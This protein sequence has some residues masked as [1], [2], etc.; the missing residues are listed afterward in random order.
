MSSDGRH[1]VC[2]AIDGDTRSL[3]R[4]LSRYGPEVRRSLCG[5]IPPQFR[6]FLSEYDVM[7]ESYAEAFLAIGQLDPNGSFSAWLRRIAK[8]NLL[9]AVKG[10]R[11]ER[12]GGNHSRVE[13][14]RGQ[15]GKLFVARRA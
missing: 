14:D 11:A 2:R 6:G 4:L 13:A 15:E 9:D 5:E 3:V 1:D 8:N 12:R 7:Q 10:L